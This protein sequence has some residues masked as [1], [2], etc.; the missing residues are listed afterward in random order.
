MSL[1]EEIKGGIKEAMMARDTVRLEV[2]RGLSTAFMNQ[3]V[4][5]NRTPQDTLTDE[6]VI[7]VI[8]R[9]AKQRKDAIE[10]FLKG[11]RQD[12]ADEDTAQL[13]ILEVYLPKMMEK[14]EVVTIVKEV[15]SKSGITDPSKK[16]MLMK[17]AMNEL[18]GK[19]DGMLVKQV[20]DEMFA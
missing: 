7:A 20:V 11:G 15:M 9:T 10:Q 18:K 3:L 16:G 6:E 14:D 8:T 12:L 13:K 1:Q 4:A 5:T 17:E 2:L 19:A